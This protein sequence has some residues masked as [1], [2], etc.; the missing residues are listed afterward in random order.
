MKNTKIKIAIMFLLFAAVVKLQAQQQ[1]CYQ[2]GLNEGI[3]IYNDAQRLQRAGRCVDAVPRYW[4][5]LSRFRLTR[6]C[7][8][9]PV[10]HELNTWEDRC[11]QGVA[12]CG[13]K[14]DETT[15]LI[16][17]Q[18][19]LSFSE[20]GG[21]LSITVN[22]NAGSW[23]IERTPAWCTTQRS[24]NVLTV[25]CSENTGTAGRRE[26]LVIVA[27]TLRYEITVEQSGRTV[28]ATPAPA[29]V[30]VTEVI[31]ENVPPPNAII[32]QEPEP[33]PI[34]PPAPPVSTAPP[35][36]PTSPASPTS[37]ISPAPVIKASAGIKAGLNLANVINDMA[38]INF[39]PEMKPDFHAGIFLNLNFGY[40]E[41]KP[42]LFGLQPEVLYSRQGFA[43]NSEKINFDYITVPLMIKLYVYQGLN[44]EF[45]PWVSYLL[46]VSPDVTAIDGSNIKLS[47]LKGGKDAGI[48]VGAGFETGFGLVAGA[49]YQY[50]LSEMASNLLWKN[51]VIALSLGWKF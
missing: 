40:R 14:V 46:T 8:D 9:L 30:T 13:G 50:G 1:S 51:N 23:R 25:T 39:S 33:E 6:S 17:S 47:D 3:E 22:T 21:S 26:N 4:E 36:F 49:R 15:V 35:V 7:R 29:S 42:G 34:P 38:N 16:A 28:V 19:L 41:N 31:P 27:N 24:N 20:E 11:I 12:A 18:G 43:L 48:A 2:I 5:A 10:N 37:P 45:G 32:V 44:F